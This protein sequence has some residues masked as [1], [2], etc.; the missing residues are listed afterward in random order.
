MRQAIPMNAPSAKDLAC[1]RLS[2]HWEALGLASHLLHASKPFDGYPFGRLTATLN[3]QI[4]RDHYLFTLREQQVVGYVGWALC[5]KKVAE[6]WVERAIEPRLNACLD[7]D[8]WIALTWYAAQAGTV[9]AQARH[10]RA[11]YPDK[12][13]V[14]RRDYGNGKTSVKRFRSYTSP[15]DGPEAASGRLKVAGTP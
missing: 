7:G 15:A 3:A 1:C 13:G 12:I 6:D 4:Q 10:L 14:G 9:L 5:S 8:H 11:L 2:N